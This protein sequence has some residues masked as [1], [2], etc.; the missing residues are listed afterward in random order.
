MARKKLSD[1]EKIKKL[2]ADL[3]YLRSDRDYYKKLW[4][5]T[6]DD[7]NILRAYFSSKLKWFIE[8]NG[9]GQ[10]PSLTYLIEDLA[11]LF[12]KIKRFDW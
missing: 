4:N 5:E 8:L 6:S 10:S 7:L 9:K 11:K 2:R 1:K 3:A 12:N